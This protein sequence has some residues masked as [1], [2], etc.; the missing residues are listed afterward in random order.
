MFKQNLVVRQ[1]LNVEQALKLKQAEL[2]AAVRGVTYQPRA[3][4]PACN[5]VLNREQIDAGFLRSRTNLTTKCVCGHRFIPSLAS[6]NELGNMLT[7]YY[8]SLQARAALEGLHK[9]PP[10]IIAKKN[11][12]AYHSAILHFGSMRAMYRLDGL[13][14]A[15]REVPQWHSAVAPF[16]GKAPDQMIAD[17]VG[18]PVGVITRMRRQARQKP[19]DERLLEDE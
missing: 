7:D 19:F 14:Y 5:T 18:V 6:R 17:V 13:Q 15:H 12:S 1:M 4:C 11:P 9:S 16:L 2:I 10:E 8:C 3:I